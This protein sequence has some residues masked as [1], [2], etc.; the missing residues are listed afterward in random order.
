MRLL[1]RCGHE[2][3]MHCTSRSG[4][5]LTFTVRTDRAAWKDAEHACLV[6][7]GGSAMG[8]QGHAAPSGGHDADPP[9]PLRRHRESR[10]PSVVNAPPPC[11][12]LGP[13]VRPGQNPAGRG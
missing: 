12:R 9:L 6:L 2:P 13:R 7:G 3:V 5:T 10:F 8:L 11:G 1:L 4:A